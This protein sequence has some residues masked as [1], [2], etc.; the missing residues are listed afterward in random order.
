MIG[1]VRV[2]REGADFRQAGDTAEEVFHLT[3]TGTW[4]VLRDHLENTF[5]V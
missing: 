5:N 4:G 3:V 2:G 1:S